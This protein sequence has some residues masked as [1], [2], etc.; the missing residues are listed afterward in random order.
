[1]PVKKVILP[2]IGLM[3]HHLGQVQ[4][5]F[6]SGLRPVWPKS[7]LF[8]KGR[9]IFSSVSRRKNIRGYR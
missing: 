9:E 2:Y 1:M 7:R 8:E 4:Q 3:A 5:V 6:N